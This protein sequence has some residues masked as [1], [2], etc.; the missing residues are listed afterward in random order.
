QSIIF[1]WHDSNRFSI[2]GIYKV[3]NETDVRA[4]FS[5][6][7]SAV[8]DAFRG[9]DDPD[10]DQMMFSAGFMHRFGDQFSATFSYSFG[11]YDDAPVHLSEPGAGTL[12]GSYE[13]W[14][15]AVGLQALILF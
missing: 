6:D 4:G 10:S 1:N 11:H 14:S 8:S 13:R 3:D 7:E 5:Y 15:H 2:G 12:I 9:S